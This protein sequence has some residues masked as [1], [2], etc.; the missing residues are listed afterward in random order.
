MEYGPAPESDKPALDW[1]A[2]HG[3]EFGI[4]VGGRWVKGSDGK[5]FD[6]INPATT[7]RLARVVQAGP[8]DVDAAGRAAREAPPGWAAIPRPRAAPPPFPPAR[9]GAKQCPLLPP[10]Q[11]RE[12]T[13]TVR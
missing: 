9:R 1:L 10:P 4:S 7:Q 12:Q 8:P 11:G 13:E 6:V 2:A 3:R 5:L